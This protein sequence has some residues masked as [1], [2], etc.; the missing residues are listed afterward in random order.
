MISFIKCKNVSYKSTKTE[1]FYDIQLNIKGKKNVYESFDDYVSTEILDDENKYDAGEYGLQKAEKGV[2]FAS[3]PPVLHLH[4]LRFQYDPMTNNSVK[5][6]DRFEF[7]EKINLDKY[8]EKPEE[9]PANYILHAVLV[10]SGDNH[11]GHYVV[12]INPRGDGNW[13]KFDDDVV[14]AVPKTA[15]IDQNYGGTDDDFMLNVRN[16]TNAYMLVYVRESEMKTILQ[17]IAEDDIPSELNEK[18]NEEKRMELAKRKERNEASNYINVNVILEDYFD[19]YHAN[20]LFN[21][22]IAHYRCFKVK[23]NS[24]LSDLVAL[25]Q[26]TFKVQ[27]TKMRLWSFSYM[28]NASGNQMYHHN[29]ASG[30][31]NVLANGLFALDLNDPDNMQ[32]PITYFSRDHNPWTLYL[33][34]L[35]P[36]VDCVALPAYSPTMHMLVFFKYY[37]PVNKNLTYAGSRIVT[38]DDKLVDLV[39]ELNKMIGTP[40]ETVL[41]FYKFKS[42][43]DANAPLNS[44][45]KNGDIL[46][47]ER[48]EKLPN[49]ELP[50][51]LDY[52]NDLQ[53]RVDV[54]FIDKNIQNDNGFTIELSVNSTYDQM[55]KVSS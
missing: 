29:S 49:L 16:C 19:G 47:F 11:G 51:Y 2:I 42:K 40:T 12:F 28:G 43:V 22:D 17:D 34:L 52:Y 10:H 37:D 7:H 6:N 8:L 45:I 38:H 44:I 48:N 39:P 5:F 27:P 31:G 35:P 53:Y 33:E 26:T 21:T 13:C 15:A 54:T 4:L 41:D 46:I 14:S 23:Q 20:D 32:N 24:S 30:G 18:L 9:T 25:I 1:T 50:T 36:D 55:A 3:F